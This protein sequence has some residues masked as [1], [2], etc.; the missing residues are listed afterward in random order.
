M[1]QVHHPKW[2]NLKIYPELGILKKEIGLINDII[3]AYSSNI[4]VKINSK[5]SSLIKENLKSFKSF[6]FNELVYSD[7]AYMGSCDILIAPNIHDDFYRKIEFGDKFI[8]FSI[9]AH[10]LFNKHFS[11]YFKNGK[12]EY[13]NLVCLA[14]IVRDAG[15][16]F[17][18]VLK[19]NLP[20]FDRWCILDTGSTD[21]TQEIIKRVLKDK[22]GTLYSEPFVNFK[23]SRNRCLDLAG[24]VCDFI[25]TLDDTY[26]LNG[27]LRK[28]LTE[29][30]GDVV[31]DSFSLLIQSNDSE[32]YSNRIIKSRTGLRY[33]HTIH[34]VIT[35][36]NN[37]NISIPPE[38]AYIF[39]KR[40]DYME[41]RTIKR[42]QQDLE[43]LFKEL[44]EKPDDPRTLYYIA[45]TYGC[46]DDEINKAK[47]FEK[48][49][50]QKG[51]VQELIDA[52]FE[53]ARSYNFTVNPETLQLY[54]LPV[55]LTDSQ[56][57]VCEG[58]YL[59]AYQ[60]DPNRPEPFYFIGI[61]YYLNREI[62]KCYVYFKKAFEL[63]YP[64]HS[65]YSLKP[66]LSY[67]FLP[68]FLTEICYYIENYNLGFQAAELFLSK[69]NPQVESWNTVNNWYLIYKHLKQM[70]H[71]TKVAIDQ[72][73]FCIVTDG[74]WEPWTGRDI[75]TKGLG[76][77][78]TWVIET[79]NSLKDKF[80][81]VV[82]CKTNCPEFY[83]GVGY[84][85][86]NL[87]S[88]FIATTQVEHCII[89][90]YTEYVPVALKGHVKK[91]YVIFHDL[92]PP[93]IILPVDPKLVC[94]F[95]LTEWHKNYIK[96]IFPQF[97]VESSYYGINEIAPVKEKIKNSFIYSSFPNRGLVVLLR[98]WKN[99]KE[100]L[101][102]AILNV[103]CDLDHAWTNQ[104]APEMMK[105]I[106]ETIHQEQ[107]VLHGWVS[108]SD[109]MDAW[110]RTDYWL[111]PCI[112]E[113]TF[114]LTALEAAISKTRVITNGLAGLA[115]TAKYGIIVPGDPFSR[116]WQNKIL[117]Q[118]KSEYY[119]DSL[120][121]QNYTFA[122]SLS[123]KKQTDKLI[124][125]IDY[126]NKLVY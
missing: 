113:E 31:A 13:D 51:Y 21:N 24:T 27:D 11:Y 59:K 67:Y 80:N 93:D 114:C 105:E 55:V 64:V 12:F 19:A 115:E 87:F 97:R 108:K 2:T 124:N 40:S 49:I 22:K 61:H 81:V 6:N 99:I 54:E 120:I 23:V 118:L 41:T 62:G 34:E 52:L 8:H 112:F 1:E 37:N 98:M 42:K 36:Q 26:I 126:D 9:D 103:Y 53:L 77:S 60:L 44:E 14:M 116:E 109:L 82:F 69:N 43:M 58:L 86:I 18:N 3:E 92:L 102:D 16:D 91:V 15:P 106:K 17:E 89:S 29:V 119:P 75:E 74:G 84:N 65:Q 10:T 57:A 68:K 28:F 73:V 35:D 117:E 94:L 125:L 88:S 56:W 38:E 46:M 72:N 111:Y 122:K 96:N 25:C 48:R 78:E 47:Y 85:P 71:L 5:N 100:I 121:E 4:N 79:A 33:I 70:P 101:P 45:Q 110:N 95:G 66:T 63:G 39:D 76:G 104:V 50:K 20:H 123:W 90:R 32:Y 83:N 30:R 7:T 107:V